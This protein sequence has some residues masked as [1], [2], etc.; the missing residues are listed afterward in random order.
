MKYSPVTCILV[1]IGKIVIS[2]NTINSRDGK[3]GKDLG[4]YYKSF[5][6]AISIPIKRNENSGGMLID[7][8]GTCRETL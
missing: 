2:L 4:N 7:L 6:K 5:V 8:I 1:D 3:A